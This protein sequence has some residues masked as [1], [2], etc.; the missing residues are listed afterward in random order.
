MEDEGS[1]PGD[2]LGAGGLDSSFY[3]HLKRNWIW[4]SYLINKTRKV[5]L[6]SKA[7]IFLCSTF[8]IW[9]LYGS[10]LLGM[11]VPLFLINIWISALFLEIS[12]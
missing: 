8:I 7:V 4:T 10:R 12:F 2:G 3:S 9:L 6:F 5:R 11:A 1:V